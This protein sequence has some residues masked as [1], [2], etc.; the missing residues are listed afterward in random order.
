[1]KSVKELIEINYNWR[2]GSCSI[3]IESI[4][5]A[6]C[7]ITEHIEAQEEPLHQEAA[8]R[9]GMIRALEWAQQ[10][11][12]PISPANDQIESAITRLRNG[13]DL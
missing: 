4:V 2:T 1:M 12:S 7:E 8:F 5:A 13:G 3:A 9:D 11:V 10:Q 6:L